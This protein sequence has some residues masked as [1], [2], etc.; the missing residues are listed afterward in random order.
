MQTIVPGSTV[1]AAAP[2]AVARKKSLRLFI[3]S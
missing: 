2:A 1:A 3:G